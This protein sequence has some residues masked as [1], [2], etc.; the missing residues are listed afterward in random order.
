MSRLVEQPVEQHE[1]DDGPGQHR[2]P[3]E[4]PLVRTAA[5]HRVMVV[6][7]DVPLTALPRRCLFNRDLFVRLL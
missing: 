1:A 6:V 2:H 7:L 5:I 4:Q 3:H